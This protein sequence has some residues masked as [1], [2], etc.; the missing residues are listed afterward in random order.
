VTPKTVELHLRNAYSK[1]GIASRRELP[2][3]LT[4]PHPRGAQKPRLH[5]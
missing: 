4:T 3:E 5:V 1:L 2:A